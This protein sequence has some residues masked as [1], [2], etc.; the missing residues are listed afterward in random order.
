MAPGNSSLLRSEVYSVVSIYLQLAEGLSMD[1]RENLI[2]KH[3]EAKPTTLWYHE[4]S[5]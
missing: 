4:V 1:L 3:F 2:F 5:T